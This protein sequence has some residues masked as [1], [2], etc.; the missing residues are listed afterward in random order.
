M[1]DTPSRPEQDAVRSALER[2]LAS[3]QFA[4]S[5]RA[6][7][8]LQYVAEAELAGRGSGLKEYILGVEVFDRSPSFDPRTDTIV[9]VEAVKL[10]K[11]LRAY[12]RGSGRLDPVLIDVPKGGYEPKFRVRAERNV[13]KASSRAK[14]VCIAVLPFVN[15]SSDPEQEYWSDGLT[16]EL[17]SSLA[18]TGGL[19][20]VSRT[21]AF[22]FKDNSIDVREIGRRLAADLIERQRPRVWRENPDHGTTDQGFDRT[23]SMVSDVRPAYRRC[24]P[25]SAGCGQSHCAGHQT[26][27]HA[28]AAAR[29]LRTNRSQSA[30]LRVISQSQALDGSTRLSIS[31]PSHGSARTRPC[32]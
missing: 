17:T 3:P 32:C 22:A 15:L 13:T 29:N 7:R 14:P 5:P 6:S 25:G 8:F 20:V 4:G 23:P 24:L 18:R 21:S 31:A 28:G 30:S 10:R 11:R 27:T 2:V 19:H 16:E 1:N 9:R 26:G 12:Y